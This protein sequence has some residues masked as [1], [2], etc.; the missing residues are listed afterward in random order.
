MSFLDD[1]ICPI[2]NVKVDNNVSRLTVFFNAILLALFLTTH[3]PYFVIL[4][5]VDYAIRV[6]G[7]AQ[8][9][10]MR[11]LAANIAGMLKWPAK[12]T[13]QAPKMFAARLGLLFSAGSAL[14]FVVSL[15]VSLIV[16]SI[17]LVFA[18]LDSVFDFCVGCLTYSYVVLPFYKGRGIRQ[19]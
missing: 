17:L 9:S 13:D 16:G 7:Q 10:P 11:W 1:V 18:T 14:F 5:A 15:P 4:C 2:S 3:I 19:G 6:A 12:M 8:Y